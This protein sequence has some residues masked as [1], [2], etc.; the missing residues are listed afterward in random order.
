MTTKLPV[1]LLALD[2]KKN[3]SQFLNILKEGDF[4]KRTDKEI[5]IGILKKNFQLIFLTHIVL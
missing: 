3:L 4:N 1:S 2:K 5:N